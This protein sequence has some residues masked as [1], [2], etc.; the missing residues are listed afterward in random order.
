MN[1]IISRIISVAMVVLLLPAALFPAKNGAAAQSKNF[2]LSQGLEVEYNILKQLSTDYVDTINFGK[3]LN[4]G[5]DAMLN[6]IDPYTEY[7]PDE[8]QEEIDLITTASYGGIGAVIRKIDSLCVVLERVYNGSTAVTYNLEP[9]DL[10]LK[11]DGADVKPLT[12]DE[13]SKKMKGTPGTDVK[14]L[15]KKGR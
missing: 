2:K 14:F 15:V 12:A 10:I 3:L 8:N 1:K 13:C 4:T 11:I 6:S 5:I 7:I 9:G